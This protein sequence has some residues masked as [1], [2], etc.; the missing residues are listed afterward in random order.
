MD[1]GEYLF[2]GDL[3]ILDVLMEDF[4]VFADQVVSQESNDVFFLGVNDH[5]HD[6]HYHFLIHLPVLRVC[7]INIL[8]E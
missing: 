5:I 8:Q 3:F 4:V 1:D 2:Q 6:Y 7:Q